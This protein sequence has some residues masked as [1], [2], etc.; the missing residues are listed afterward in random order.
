MAFSFNG[1]NQSQIA[2]TGG[3]SMTK[4]T[5]II[6]ASGEVTN[7]S[8]TI[9]TVPANKRWIIVAA[10]LSVNIGSDGAAGYGSIQLNDVKLLSNKAASNVTVGAQV[11]SSYNFDY[12]TAPIITEGQTIKVVSDAAFIKVAGQIVYI[13][14][15]V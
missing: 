10:N 3:V 6:L 13:E 4:M 12:Q 7:T 2:I 1:I 8:S 5:P 15:S 14:E 9:G 11:S